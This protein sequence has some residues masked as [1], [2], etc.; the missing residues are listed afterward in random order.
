MNSELLPSLLHPCSHCGSEMQDSIKDRALHCHSCGNTM[1]LDERTAIELLSRTFL[2]EAEQLGIES[3]IYGK[4]EYEIDEASLPNGLLPLIVS[5]IHHSSAHLFP[6]KP[7][8]FEIAAMPESDDVFTLT[9]FAI[10][11]DTDTKMD[12]KTS[13]MLMTHFVSRMVELSRME[14]PGNTIISDMRAMS[15]TELTDGFAA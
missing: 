7:Y 2:K 5:R 11:Y 14:D 6:D 4:T 10:R 13:L 8:P 9:E 1:S 12:I 15:L 3:I